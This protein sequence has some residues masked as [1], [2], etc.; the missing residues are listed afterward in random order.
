MAWPSCCEGKIWYLIVPP[1]AFS[2]DLPH[3]SNEACSGCCGGTQCAIL[4]VMALSCAP[5]AVEAPNEA[6]ATAAISGGKRWVRAMSGSSA[7]A[8][9][10]RPGQRTKDPLERAIGQRPHLLVRSILDGVR[11]EHHCRIV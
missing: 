6:T 9:S 4:S 3:I 7:P 1:E 10:R 11:D 5:A 8:N 2:T